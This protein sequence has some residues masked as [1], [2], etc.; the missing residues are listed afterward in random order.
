MTESRTDWA[1]SVFLVADGWQDDSRDWRL[2][3]DIGDDG[4][5]DE[6][7]DDGEDKAVVPLL[8]LLWWEDEDLVRFSGMSQSISASSDGP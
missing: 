8:L 5:D 2:D 6:G 7:D 4:D 3:S 1:D